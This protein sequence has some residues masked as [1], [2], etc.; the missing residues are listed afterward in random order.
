MAA[1]YW[2]GLSDPEPWEHKEWTKYGFGFDFDVR[3]EPDHYFDDTSDLGE[4]TSKW[5]EG[6]IRHDTG[7]FHSYQWFVPLESVET[8]RREFSRYGFARHEADLMAREIVRKNYKRACDYG[9]TWHHVVVTVKASREGVVLGC[10]SLG[11]IDSDSDD[12]YFAEV[13][14][15]LRDE[16]RTEAEDA[17]IRITK[18]LQVS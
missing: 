15:E 3:I 13:A 1:W 10:A 8:L 5:Q 16:A 7:V 9:E 4:F 11:G 6:A 12:S 2:A 17:L 18:G 14:L